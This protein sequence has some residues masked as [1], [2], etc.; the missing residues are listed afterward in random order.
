[1]HW[2][3]MTPWAAV[4]LKVA[5]EFMEDDEDELHPGRQLNVGKESQDGTRIS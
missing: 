1:M 3:A 4:P 2:D 5:R